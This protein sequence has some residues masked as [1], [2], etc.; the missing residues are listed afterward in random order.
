MCATG[1]GQG[2]RGEGEAADLILYRRSECSTSAAE[3]VRVCRTQAGKQLR[4]SIYTGGNLYRRNIDSRAGGF[5][6]P[7]VSGT[8]H[9]GV[10]GTPA[11]LTISRV[12]YRLCWRSA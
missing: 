6:A 3:I 11:P 1:S 5:P 2:R 12:H 7:S 4:V 8:D 10:P 9:G